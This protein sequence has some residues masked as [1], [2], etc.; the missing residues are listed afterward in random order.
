MEEMKKK[1][2]EQK[3]VEFIWKQKCADLETN[4]AKLRSLLP[5]GND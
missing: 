5:F 3:A 1:E 4:I 2:K